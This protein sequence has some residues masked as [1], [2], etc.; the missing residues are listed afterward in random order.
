MRVTVIA[1]VGVNHN[2]DSSL[3]IELVDASIEAG[4]DVVKF[5]VFDPVQ[6]VTPTAELAPYQAKSQGSGGQAEMLRGLTLTPE[7]FSAIAKQCKDR[8]GEL[9]A[10]PFDLDSLRFIVNELGVGRVKIGSGDLT[11]APLIWSAA[12]SRLPLIL[13]T[14]MATLGEVEAALAVAGHGYVTEVEPRSLREA[15]DAFAEAETRAMLSESVTLLHCTTA[16]PAPF[17]TVQLRAMDV[18]RDAFPLRV[19]FSDHTPGVA[20]SIAA[21]AR[22]ATVIEKHITVDRSL[23]GPDHAASLTPDE[24][25][26]LVRGVR[27]VEAA[28]GD[29]WKAL[30]K[31]EMQNRE[32]A[33]RG[34]VASRDIAA[35]ATIAAGDLAA[36][37]PERGASPFRYWDL[38]GRSAGQTYRP[39]DPVGRRE[40]PGAAASREYSDV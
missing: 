22:G 14:G 20:I 33:R 25:A 15:Y 16:Y 10:T 30:Q 27:A 7:E 21:A 28:L 12:A 31:V 1:E 23:P 18:L 35:G 2:G 4:A 37:R 34:L 3:A 26:D 6:L 29:G 13:S 9:L 32:V 5:Q 8:G 17:E 40:G 24:F 39:D 11:N 19:G 36:R 38:I